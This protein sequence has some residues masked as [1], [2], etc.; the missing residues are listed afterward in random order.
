MDDSFSGGSVIVE[1]GATLVSILIPDEEL[2]QQPDVETPDPT[3]TQETG[4]ARIKREEQRF[5]CSRRMGRQLLDHEKLGKSL[6]VRGGFFRIQ[7]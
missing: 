7:P 5:P 6:E 1:V 2:I 3:C 4:D